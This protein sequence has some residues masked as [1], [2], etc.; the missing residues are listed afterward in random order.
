MSTSPA[1]DIAAILALDGV[2]TEGTDLFVDEIPETPDFCV[3]VRNTTGFDANPA[4][5]R[6]SPTVQVIIRGNKFGG[7]VAYNKAIDVKNALLGRP[8]TIV[9]SK[10]YVQFLLTGDIIR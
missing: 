10:S 2:A 6:D 3:V 4:Y 1:K 5:R 7:E 8:T 9:N